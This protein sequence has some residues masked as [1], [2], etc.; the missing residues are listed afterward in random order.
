MRRTYLALL[1]LLGG[2]GG[3][4]PGVE[5]PETTKVLDAET[6]SA[7]ASVSEDL[8][9]FVFSSTTAQLDALAPGDVIVADVHPPTLPTGT[10]R[11]VV[12]VDRTGA[13]P[14]V[15]AGP[16]TLAEAI[17]TG[18][19]DQTVPLRA[20]TVA[21]VSGKQTSWQIGPDGIYVG[22]DNVVIY[23]Y[24]DTS[25][26]TNDQVILDGNLA[27]EPDFHVSFDISGFSLEELTFEVTGQLSANLNV[28]ARREAQFGDPDGTLVS[29]IHFTPYTFLIGP[30]PVVLVPTMGIYVGVDGKVTA[31]ANLG[32]KVDASTT[33]GF[34]YHDGSFGPIAEVDYG[35]TLEVPSF[36]DGATGD[37]R[38]FARS[39]LTVT[40]YGIA[41][42]YVD[43]RAYA[44]AYV[45]VAQDPWW[46]L[47]AG[48]EGSAVAH[49]GIE[50]DIFGFPIA[51]IDIL[52]KEFASIG[53]LENC[54]LDAG[55]PAPSV[56][57][58]MGSEGVATWARSYGGASSDYPV[59]LALVPDGGAIVAGSSLSWDATPADA[60]LVKTDA[61]GHV[62]WD[63]AFRDLDVATSVIALPDGYLVAAGRLGVT[64]GMS[65]LLRLDLNGKLVWARSIA[66]ADGTGIAKLVATGDGGALAVGTHGYGATADF[67]AARFD[68]QGGLV[69]SRRY[70]S[71]RSDTAWDAIAT[72][73]GGFLLV[74]QVPLL[75]DGT[76]LVK[77]DGQGQIM[78]QR[79]LDGD[80]NERGYFVAESPLGGYVVGGD[81]GGD[82]I[83]IRLD[84]AG[85][86]VWQRRFDAGS[87][88]EEAYHAAVRAD[89]EIVVVGKRGLGTA[90]DF[91]VLAVN[92]NGTLDW[93]RSMGGAA[94]DL[95]AGP[96]P[97]A[98]GGSPVLATPDGGVLVAG[99]TESFGAGQQ[100]AWL[101]KIARN[102]Y[103]QV[104]PTS[105]ADTTPQSGAFGV[106]G[107]VPTSTS[108]VPVDLPLTVSDLTA[109]IVVTTTVV[110]NQGVLP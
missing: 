45:D 109:E 49:V 76:W 28:D 55:G 8:Q 101:V 85:G 105:G 98:R 74:G 57:A 20:S 11:R 9:T 80:G 12:A 47:C 7:L 104:D 13:G 46:R 35:G 67:F 34:G 37:A 94:Q 23:D 22:F 27:I 38:A 89:G 51:H 2:C 97:Y 81:L 40:A 16:A 24:D 10:L 108:A 82:A 14:V 39:H 31:Q 56:I 60:W 62:A 110:E 107:V 79:Y 75:F 71:G 50:I 66:S 48:V 92:D 88:Y 96:G 41:G 32:L 65:Y 87:P 102:G 29:T 42:G 52:D 25:V 1:L 15:T 18:A 100:D 36:Q 17:E 53:P 26:T 91:W 99:H 59:S 103:L 44:R 54:L 93:S 63:V 3:D 69:W 72:S 19:I 77:I 73:D 6:L 78:F 58:G 30:V 21:G 84:A 86:I 68:A 64:T 106:T 95:A 61:L 43:L 70:D 83:V 90:A 4:D 33:L 5:I